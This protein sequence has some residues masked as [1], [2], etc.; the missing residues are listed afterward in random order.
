MVL[1]RTIFSESVYYWQSTSYVTYLPHMWIPMSLW[2]HAHACPHCKVPRQLF[3]P[4]WLHCKLQLSGGVNTPTPTTLQRTEHNN[5]SET[6]AAFSIFIFE[7]HWRISKQNVHAHNFTIKYSHW[8]YKYIL[9]IC[10]HTYVHM[11]VPVDG[12]VMMTDTRSYTHPRLPLILRVHKY[13]HTSGRAT[14][15]TFR[16]ASITPP[17]SLHTQ[18]SSCL[19]ELLLMMTHTFILM[20]VLTENTYTHP[21]LCPRLQKH[22]CLLHTYRCVSLAHMRRYTQ[23][24]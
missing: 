24:A 7:F 18:I 10:M 12:R 15:S 3:F 14:Y 23:L 16:I 6:E 17:P 1:L 9:Y 2:F 19:L 11:Q 20:P 4:S 22:M 8:N 13:T 5:H 21:Y